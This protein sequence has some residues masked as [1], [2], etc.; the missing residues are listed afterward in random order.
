MDTLTFLLNSRDLNRQGVLSALVVLYYDYSLTFFREVELF[1]LEP[2]FTWPSF[3]FF[4]T[5]YSALLAHI[6]IVLE[7][8][9]STLSYQIYCIY[10]ATLLVALQIIRT[11]AIFER[12][13]YLLGFLLVLAVTLLG[14]SAWAFL[15]SMRYARPS[16]FLMSTGER[17]CALPVTDIQGR[18][19][20]ISW[21][22]AAVFDTVIFLLTVFKRVH[23]GGGL[24]G[25][26]LSMML[27]DGTM[28]YGA[29]AI[30][31]IVDFVNLMTHRGIS[32][33]VTITNA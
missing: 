12:N 24:K 11:Y 20:A 5:R 27:R 25:G 26:L 14:V 21:S 18:F 33:V 23:E 3:F 29:L 6:P 15:R 31:Y 13:N 30:L 4:L 22:S 17:I 9:V 16:S 1:W 7:F 10:A 32:E 28:Y 2:R 19:L 8:F